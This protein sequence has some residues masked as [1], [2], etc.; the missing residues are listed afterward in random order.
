MGM[1]ISSCAKRNYLL[2]GMKS[3]LKEHKNVEEELRNAFNLAAEIYP[4]CNCL[5]WNLIRSFQV[6]VFH[7]EKYNGSFLATSYGHGFLCTE[8]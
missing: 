6:P 1:V 8:S 3:I 5:C 2:T 4:E 7:S